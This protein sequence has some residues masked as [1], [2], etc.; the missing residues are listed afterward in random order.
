MMRGQG[1]IYA[2]GD[3]LWIYFYAG[4]DRR[5]AVGKLVGKEPMRT[6]W[7][8][9]VKALKKRLEQKTVARVT[10]SIL[11]QKQERL[12]VSELLDEYRTHRLV[13]GVKNI[14]GFKT[15]VKAN[16]AWWGHLIASRLTTVML[17]AVI[18]RKR[19][20]GSAP[21][22]I[23]T[24]L[25]GLVA[26]LRWAKH[27]LPPM[28]DIPKVSAPLTRKGTVSAEQLE[29]FCAVARPWVAD[30]ARFGYLSGWRI[31]EVLD[32]TWDRV[33]LKRGLLFLD[34]SKTDDPRVRPLEGSMRELLGRRLE[35]RRLGCA[36]VFHLDGLPITDERFRYRWR[37]ACD[38]AGMPG[39]VFHDFRRGVYDRVLL[40]TGDLITAMDL[41]GHKSLSS[42]RRYARPRVDRMQAVLDRLDAPGAKRARTVAAQQ[43]P[44]STSLPR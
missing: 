40:E 3:A 34:T 21:G 4:G 5:E 44:G 22:T 24:R 39:K 17:E 19:E 7:D 8:D 13:E 10:G 18:E 11:T 15:A 9:A 12:T 6:T 25:A 16:K 28:P 35:A 2:R 36:L 1:T 23:K 37:E 20:A 14:P 41:V 26:A 29:A 33:D 30:I 32:L 38:A 42:A 31:S 43:G 27:R